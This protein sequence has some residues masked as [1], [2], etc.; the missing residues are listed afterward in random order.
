VESGKSK[1]EVVLPLKPE[2]L[3][4][5]KFTPSSGG[6]YILQNLPAV[7]GCYVPL[8]RGKNA[9]A[10]NTHAVGGGKN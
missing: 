3:L 8:W 6:Q 7:K 2:C 9:E 5:S 10:L 4:S 1:V